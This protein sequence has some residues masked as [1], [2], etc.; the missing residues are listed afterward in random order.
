MGLMAGRVAA[1]SRL[2]QIGRG[3]LEMALE[4]L[5]I[6]FLLPT[7]WLTP[8]IPPVF[9]LYSPCKP[10]VLLSQ[11][12]GYSLACRTPTERSPREDFPGLGLKHRMSHTGYISHRT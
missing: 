10:P 2:L 8:C 3:G 12:S 5:A 1:S 4:W 6:G 11:L 9:P 7:N